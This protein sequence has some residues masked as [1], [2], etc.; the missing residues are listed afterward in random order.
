[1]NRIKALSCSIGVV[2]LCIASGIAAQGREGEALE[3]IIV[4]AQKRNESLQTVPVSVSVTTAEMLEQRSIRN[5]VD[6]SVNTPGF[7]TD[8]VQ[9]NTKTGIRGFTSTGSDIIESPVVTLI[10]GAYVSNS[11]LISSALYD[12]DRIEVLHGPQGTLFGKNAI[13]GVLHVITR[14]PT[15]ETSGYLNVE[16]GSYDYFRADGAISGEIADGVYGRISAVSSQRSGW[17]SNSQEPDG[18]GLDDEAIRARLRWDATEKLR[19]DLKY[20]W[21]QHWSEGSVQQLLDIRDPSILSTRRFQLMSARDLETRADDKQSLGPG[22]FLHGTVLDKR[23]EGQGQ[24]ADMAQIKLTYETEGGY[25]LMS[26]TNWVDYTNDR[27]V[28]ANFTAIGTLPVWN[29]QD[30]TTTSQEFQI[31]SQEEG[32]FSW[33]GGAYI[34]RTETERGGPA[35]LDFDAGGGI[36][37]AVIVNTLLAPWYLQ[38]PST[39]SIANTGITVIQ[40]ALISQAG[41]TV[42]LGPG[43]QELQRDIWSVYFE[44]RYD[45]NEQWRATLGV[46]YTQDKLDGS[47]DFINKN[48]YGDPLSSTAW[49]DPF[50]A[51]ISADARVQAAAAV[52]PGG[53]PAGSLAPGFP[54]L[55]VPD[56]FY[57][58]VRETLALGY[59]FIQLPDGRVDDDTDENGLTPSVKIQYMP[60]DDTMFYAT[61]STGFKGGGFNF[62]AVTPSGATEFD[63]EEAIGYEIGSK[64]TLLDGSAR[65][66]VALFRTE[67]DDLQV[68]SINEQNT[69]TFQNAASAVSQGL[70]L[71]ATWALNEAWTVNLNYMYLDA[72]YDEFE[73]A[74]CRVDD[75]NASSRS[76]TQDLSGEDL[77]DAPEH[78][79]SLMVEYVQMLSEPWE[80]QGTLGATYRDEFSVSGANDYW[81]D[82]SLQYF[83]RIALVN[84]RDNWLIALRGTNLSDEDDVIYRLPQALY[85]NK[86]VTGAIL[87]PRM[88]SVQVQKNF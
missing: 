79:G 78:S 41:L 75:P 11:R 68:T 17:M 48:A 7:Y 77:Q 33:I 72:T 10:D 22:N 80:L 54:I 84:E 76:C 60:S 47:K 20:E 49:L 69:F 30:Y 21:M 55:P 3:E 87:P 70:E 44:G 43:L 66:N 88:F 26:M 58:A 81:A 16:G 14:E 32:K 65:L 6:L 64:L 40:D 86:L 36:S 74:P 29:Y 24:H 67:F 56:D 25:E 9:T 83:G 28:D 85:S 50:M 46:R 82:D 45:I 15:E 63:P 2:S 4:S 19:V 35:Y 31:R 27:K 13:A 8:D 73:G 1:M 61:V 39:L 51:K 59:S 42:D 12:V 37:D 18:G 52:Y 23:T 71:E 34:E 5:L 53:V 38:D 62:D 57:A